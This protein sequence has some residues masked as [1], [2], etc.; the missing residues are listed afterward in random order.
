MDGT[1]FRLK[2]IKIEGFKGF[3]S[4]RTIPLNGKH[5]FVLGPNSYGKSSMVEAIR[6]GLFG[7]TRRPGEVVAN[8]GYVG[9]CRVEL[10]LERENREWTLKRTLIRGVSGGSDADIVDN[11]G[12]SHLLREVLP[13]LESAPAGEGMHIIYAA[14]SAPLRRPAEDVSPFERTIYSYLGLADVRIAISRLDNFIE[15]QEATEKRLAEKLDEKRNEI[16]S[17]LSLLTSQCDQIIKTPPWGTGSVPTREDT[18][19][20]MGEFIKELSAIVPIVPTIAVGAEINL[21][22]REAETFVV[23]V[24]HSKRDEVE[25]TQRGIVNKLGRGQSLLR[26]LNNVSGQIQE[27]KNEMASIEQ[28]LEKEL[29][30]ETLDALT[31]TLEEIERQVEEAALLHDIR[32]KAHTWLTRS[33]NKSKKQRCPLCGCAPDSGDLLAELANSVKLCSSEEAEIVAKRDALKLR[34]DETLRLTEHIKKLQ[35]KHIAQQ[36][37]ENQAKEEIQEFLGIK[38]KQQDISAAL[39]QHIGRLEE[40]SLRIDKQ[41]KEAEGLHQEWNRKLDRFKDEVRFHGLQEQILALQKQQQQVKQVEAELKSLTLFGDS[42][43]VISEVLQAALNNKLKS[44]LPEINRKL[45]EAFKTLTE[46][47]A[48]NIVF[49]DETILPKLELR[50]ASDD[51]PLPGWVPSQIL[52]GQ[53]LNALELVPY[54]AFSELT[55]LPFEVYLLLLDDPTQ[56]FDPHHIEILVAKLAELGKRVQLIVASHETDHFRRLL[57]KYFV[58][59]NYGIIHATG[60]SRQDGPTLEIGSGGKY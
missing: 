28:E 20:K 50:V 57:P 46:H 7:S 3:T 31:K 51:A 1:G 42:V 11:L 22:M 49:I 43:R 34:R 5:A 9:S 24:I 39:Q 60:F 2:Q 47:P 12:Q 44:E 23:N 48:Y 27:V 33:R 56:S 36:Q 29:A 17:Q 59:D 30:G 6:W 21:L 8:Q 25:T 55:D 13:Q 52:N 40:D 26:Q 35:E 10:S 54:F 45:T 14:Q 16:D 19:T 15:L 32:S 18:A 4:S 41:L 37:E 53:A 58:P 38:S